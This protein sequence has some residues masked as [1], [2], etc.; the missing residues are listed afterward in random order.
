MNLKDI[1][2]NKAKRK[3]FKFVSFNDLDKNY[4]KTVKNALIG[5]PDHMIEFFTLKNINPES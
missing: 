4:Q 2:N 1:N 3:N 5:I